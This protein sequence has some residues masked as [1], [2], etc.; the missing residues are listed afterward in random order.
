MPMRKNGKITIPEIERV[1]KNG[2]TYDYYFN[3]YYYI[4]G[5]N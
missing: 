5:Y 4:V 2:E 3:E 1:Q